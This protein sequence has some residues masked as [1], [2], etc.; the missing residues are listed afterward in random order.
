M[1]KRCVAALAAVAGCVLGVAAPA[2]AAVPS[3][4]A[5]R[6]VP[7]GLLPVATSWPAPLRGIVLGYPSSTAGDRPSLIVTGDPGR[8]WRPLPAPPV[9]YADKGQPDVTWRAGLSP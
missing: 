6:A 2:A 1:F 9:R 5:G 4:G 8:T 3:A 7:R